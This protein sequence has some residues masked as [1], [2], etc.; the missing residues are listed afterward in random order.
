LKSGKA[1]HLKSLV[2][3]IWKDTASNGNA[4]GRNISESMRGGNVNEMSTIGSVNV[5]GTKKEMK[6]N[7]AGGK[8]KTDD[9][10][11]DTG[12]IGQDCTGRYQLLA[13]TALHMA[14]A[15]IQLAFGTFPCS[16]TGW[17]HAS[18]LP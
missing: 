10:S 13:P 5:E 1:P 15:N 14:H 18:R 11:E 4:N 9:E 8:K 2:L 16:R 6:R 12:R 7:V 17:R 3:T